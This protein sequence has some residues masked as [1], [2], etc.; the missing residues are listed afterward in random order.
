MGPY[1][2]Q[3]LKHGSPP[4]ETRSDWLYHT[5]PRKEAK[6]CELEDRK[7]AMCYGNTQPRAKNTSLQTPLAEN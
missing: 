5:T 6:R 3:R 1:R 7:A 4:A 2:Q